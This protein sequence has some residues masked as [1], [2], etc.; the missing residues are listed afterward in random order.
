MAQGSITKHVAKDGTITYRARAE[1]GL[2]PA[3]GKRRQPLKTHRTKAAAQA[4]LR[5]QQR[6]ADLGIWADG[7]KTTL[8]AWITQWLASVGA[9]NRRPSTLHTYAAFLDR[10]TAALGQT[11]L[12]RL[13]AAQ[14]EAFFHQQEAELAPSSVRTI[15]AVLHTC[16]ADA[17]RLALIADNPLRRVRPP[18]IPAKERPSWTVEQARVFWELVRTDEDLALWLI[19]LLA[20]LRIGE[21]LALRWADVNF[22]AG[23]LQVRR[24]ITQ[25]RE[26]RPILGA[27]TKS[28]KERTAVLAPATVDALRT[29]RAAVL[30]LRLAHA[31]I[32]ID[33]D[34]VFPSP[35]GAPRQTKQL[36]A[37]LDVLCTQAG[38]PRLTPHGLRHTM[39]SLLTRQAPA[40]V[41]RDLLGHASIA[42]TNIY[43]H[44]STAD[45]Q[46]AA[47]ALGTTITG[48]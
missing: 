33:Q 46:A 37:R 22:E 25:D 7:G 3:T 39:G 12:A 40:A 41:A 29:Q 43:L 14:L 16:L 8:E 6:R 13:R 19:L 45:A 48:R 18:R 9:R 11:P 27:T 30:S 32:W 2:D 38:L 36:R 15:F 21:A 23:T 24:T 35:L 10:V 42:T 20:G 44:G 28:G 5:E 1:G 31:D 47:A 4:W 17:E 26:G 34:L